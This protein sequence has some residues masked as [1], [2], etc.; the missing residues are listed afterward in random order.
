MKTDR[1]IAIVMTLLER[2]RIGA[3]ELAKM[4]EVSTRTIYRDVESLAMAGVPVFAWRGA[5]GGVGIAEGYKIDGSVFTASDIGTLLAGM[6]G[7]ASLLPE[8]DA[9]RVMAKIRQLIPPTQADEVQEKAERFRVDPTPWRGASLSFTPASTRALLGKISCAMDKHS[10]VSFTYADREGRSG[11]RRVEPGRLVLKE[12]NW[13]LHGYCRVRC[14]FRLFKLSR[15]S[16]LKTTDERFEPRPLPPEDTR[17][18][19]RMREREI[20]IELLID[21]SLRGRVADFYDGVRFEPLGE[22]FRVRL[23][24]VE[25]DFGYGVL[26]SFGDKCEC[27]GPPHV[28]AEILRRVDGIRALYEK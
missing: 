15:I 8:R 24:F 5:K 17:F 25:S 7:F 18:S 23:P 9:V 26:L 16:G 21:A 27:V 2:K 3:S 13:Y 19:D 28:R 12:M 4:F 14:D 6:G 1:L 20:E 11:E 22:R 10:V